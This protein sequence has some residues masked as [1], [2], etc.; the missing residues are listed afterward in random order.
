MQQQLFNQMMQQQLFNQM[1]NM[2]NPVNQTEELI[3][4]S[5]IP[6]LQRMDRGMKKKEIE[7]IPIVAFTASDHSDHICTICQ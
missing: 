4:N 5:V 3:R 1:N 7:L 6:A 2:P